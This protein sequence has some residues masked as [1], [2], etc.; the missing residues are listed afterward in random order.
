VQ[1]SFGVGKTEEEVCDHIHG[2]TPDEGSNMLKA[3]RIFEGAGCVCH[4]AQN[5]LKFAVDTDDAAKSVFDKVKGIVAHFHR[6]NKVISPHRIV[7]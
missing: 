6:S 1:I 2:C 7:F 4:R 3:W 5:C